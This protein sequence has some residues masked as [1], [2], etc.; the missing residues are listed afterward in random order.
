MVGYNIIYSDFFSK[1]PK[2]KDKI[3]IM[4]KPFTIVGV[5]DKI[6]NNQDDSNIIITFDA[7]RPAFRDKKRIQHH[8]C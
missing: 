1:R 7:A 3:Y 5:L 2:I 6:G 4:D 8:S